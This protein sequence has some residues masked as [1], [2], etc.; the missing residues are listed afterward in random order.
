MTQS[1]NKE[2]K[3]FVLT[4]MI[5]EGLYEANEIKLFRANSRLD[6]AK[7]M[8]LT[9][10]KLNCWAKAYD[11]IENFD[12]NNDDLDETAR[13]LLISIDQS[14]VDGGSEAKVILDQIQEPKEIVEFDGIK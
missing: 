1:T 13:L 7:Y 8:L 2:K 6:V 14:E 4:S 10:C 5:D 11:I 9:R 12:R 3:L